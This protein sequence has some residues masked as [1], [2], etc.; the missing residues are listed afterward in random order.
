[1]A[2]SVGTE[3]VTGGALGA[4]KLAEVVL[5]AM[6]LR[7]L[8]ETLAKGKSGQ[9]AATSK[10]VRRQAVAEGTG[11]IDQSKATLAALALVDA[12][13]IVGAVVGEAEGGNELEPGLA[14]SAFP[15]VSVESEAVSRQTAAIGLDRP[16]VI[17]FQAVI[18]CGVVLTVPSITQS[19]SQLEGRQ[20]SG[21]T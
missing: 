11:I 19:I 17:T 1:M 18:S 6:I 5:S 14:D 13:L 10:L 9:T 15:G 2:K 16:S 12:D 7:S 4:H 8:A 21:A 20:A 3:V